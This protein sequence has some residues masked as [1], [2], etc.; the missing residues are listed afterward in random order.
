MPFA[1]GNQANLN[2]RPVGS[3]DPTRRVLKAIGPHIAQLA[4]QRLADALKGDKA[5]ADA[6]LTLWGRL[7]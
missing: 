6:V 7:K 1:K 3:G 5:A 2:G 4:E